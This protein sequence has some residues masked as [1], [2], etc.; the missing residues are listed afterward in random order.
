MKLSEIYLRAATTIVDYN[1]YS[2]RPTKSIC[3]CD[4]IWIA[5][6]YNH[7]RSKKVIEHFAEWFRPDGEPY[8]W[9]ACA[10][11]SYEDQE[12]R[13]LALLFAHEI[14]KDEGL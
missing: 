3:C 7:E 8:W 9:W 6:S 12:A 11:T 2:D 14:A 4:A 10:K 1:E 13:R 5:C